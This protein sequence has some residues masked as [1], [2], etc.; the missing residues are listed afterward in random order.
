MKLHIKQK[1]SIKKRNEQEINLVKIDNINA[2]LK[3]EIPPD[4][5][6]LVLSKFKSMILKTG[7][8]LSLVQ[9]QY[10]KN[11]LKFL[12]KEIA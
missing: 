9:N 4:F 10:M 8:P 7:C 2:S 11:A 6:I 12:V 1:H 3:V 5:D